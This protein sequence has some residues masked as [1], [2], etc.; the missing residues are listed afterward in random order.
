MY[1]TATLTEGSYSVQAGL[2]LTV[3]KG[4]TEPTLYTYEERAI[5]QENALKYDWAWNQKEKAVKAADRY[6]DKIDMIYNLWLREGFPRSSHVCLEGDPMYAYCDYCGEYL[7]EK[8][9]V[10]PFICDPVNNPWKVTCP[11][12]KR[13]F[14]SNDSTKNWQTRAC[15]SMSCIRKWAK[16]GV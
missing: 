11:N 1:L 2:R 9:G 5:A 7:V 3:T 10:Y 4:K 8:Y 12:C 14:P 6:V 16:A 15:W 13:D